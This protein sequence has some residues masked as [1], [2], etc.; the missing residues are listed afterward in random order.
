MYSLPTS[1]TFAAFTIASAASIDPINPLVSTIPSA[2]SD[3]LW[4]PQSRPAGPGIGL[5][6]SES[7]ITTRRTTASRLWNE[8]RL[9]YCSTC[10]NCGTD[11]LLQSSAV[12]LVIMSK[13]TRALV[14]ALAAALLAGCGSKDDVEPPVAAPALS[15]SRDRVPIGSP[16]KLTYRFDVAANAKID[17]DYWVFVHVLEPDGERLWVDDHLPPTPTSTW[18]PGQ[19]VEYTRTVFVPNYPYIGPAIVR[20]G[21]YDPKTSKRLTLTGDPGVTEGVSGREVRAPAAVREH[22]PDLQGRMA[23]G[24]SLVRRSQHRV[25]VD[26]E[27]RHGLVPEPEEGRNGLSSSTPRRIDKFTSAAT[28]HPPHRR[29]DHRHLCRGL[30]RK[31]AR[32]VPG[33]GRPARLRRRRGARPRRRPDVHSRWVRYA[34]AR[35][36]GL[37]LVRRRKVTSVFSRYRKRAT[38]VPPVSSTVLFLDT[39]WSRMVGYPFL[40]KLRLCFVTSTVILVFARTGVVREGGDRLSLLEPD[41]I[42][43]GASC[44]RGFHHSDASER[45]GGD[46]RQVAHRRKSC[47]DEVPYPEPSDLQSDPQAPRTGVDLLEGTPYGEIIAAMSEAHG[48]DPLLVRALIQVESNYEAEGKI[49]Q[50]RHGADAADAVDR[51]GVQGPEPVRPPRQHRSWHQAPEVR[52]STGG[53]PRWRWPRTTPGKAP[54]RSSTAF[55]RT[56]KP[57]TTSRRFW[58]SPA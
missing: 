43:Q 13:P 17:G 20:L 6:Q 56:R 40:M 46:L 51:P 3:I 37:P 4:D 57:G 41:D 33:H 11:S 30:E 18:K 50:R 34:R 32:H 26:E 49:P 27:V 42:G 21:L 47:R 44:R 14:C 39:F 28:G 9:T 38:E 1:T 8:R 36:S 48:V 55:L 23:P 53:G 19:K 5:R 45:W 10:D 12:L 7:D 58:R 22:L 25:A 31:V 52:S 15:V 54:S 16:L 35:D 29:S 2:S 24:R